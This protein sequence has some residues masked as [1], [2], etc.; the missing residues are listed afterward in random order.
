MPE[1][2]V[3]GLGVSGLACALELSRH[4]ISFAAFDR[5]AVVGGLARS[6]RMAG[7]IFD[8]GPHVI[9]QIP[10]LFDCLSLSLEDCS[11]DSVIFPNL[12]DPISIPA[13]IQHHLHHLPLPERGKILTDI[14]WRNLSRGHA[15]PATFQQRLRTQAGSTLFDLF[16][17]DYE[18]KRLRFPLE[19]I[20]PAM[21]NRIQEPSLAGVLGL[22]DANHPMACGGNDTRFK[23]PSLG[24][25]DAVP[26]A[27]M[28]LLPQHQVHLRH[29]LSEI[30][31]HRK[32]VAFADGHTECFE[33]LI[34]SLPLPETIALLKD[35]PAVIVDASRHL[36]YSSLYIFNIGIDGAP[37]PSWGI[38]R[39]PKRDLCVYRVTVPSNYS[40]AKVPKGLSAL[41]IEVA[42]HEQ[43]YPLSEGHARAL[44]Y[45]DLAQL[46]ILASPKDVVVE[47][48]HN[49]RYGHVIHDMHTRQ[50][51]AHIFSF[52]AQYGVICCG[53]YGEW[54]DMLIPHAIQSGIDAARK[55][56]VCR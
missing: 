56:I 25:I 43:R 16:F 10:P 20:D 53:K 29:S 32:Q 19:D 4:N 35:P 27:L 40:Q 33:K 42:H 41:T 28:N 31:L 55:A 22:R 47:W 45:E 49:I 1:V 12:R 39:I 36:V 48:L 51:L 17:R 52:L 46:A 21:P 14:L 2:I 24:G 11:C 9:L 54:R 37:P 26:R 8:Y 44:I 13:P 30:D 5:E 3:V 6:E 7:F 15:K 38:A 23:Y 50:A 34:L 18:L